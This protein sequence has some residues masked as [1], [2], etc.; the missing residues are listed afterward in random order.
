[1]P[2]PVLS[3][4]K[5]S[6]F[7][8]KWQQLPVQSVIN[9]LINPFLL[10]K[11]VTF[12]NVALLAENKIMNILAKEKKTDENVSILSYK[13]LDQYLTE[14]INDIGQEEY[15]ENCESGIEFSCFINISFLS[16]KIPK[17]SKC[18]MIIFM[19]VFKMHTS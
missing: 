1:M 5:T 2:F 19:Q 16:N 11:K 4:Y 12:I 3:V 6:L 8:V 9:L 7:L 13:E 15:L 18:N 14:M 10:I 17:E